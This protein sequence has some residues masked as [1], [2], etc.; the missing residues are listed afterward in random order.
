MIPY[1]T[2]PSVHLFGSVSLHAYGV[3]FVI[4]IVTAYPVIMKRAA[5]LE[6]ATRSMRRALL[7]TFAVGL[8]GAHVVEILFYQPDKLSTEGFW[9]FFRIFSGL[10]SVGA[11]F[12]GLLGLWIY[13]RRKGMPWIGHLSIVVEGFIVWWV[14]LRLGCALSHDHLGN[15]TAFVLAFNY[16]LGPRHNLGFYEFL[17]VLLV[18]I[19]LTIYCR[20]RKVQPGKYVGIMFL[21]YGALRFALDFLR[22]TDLP[23]ADPRYWGL[24]A[25]QY[26]CLALLGAGAWLL[27]SHTRIGERRLAKQRGSNLHAHDAALMT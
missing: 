21:T 9:I 15:A 25:A 8:V 16:P 20:H 1:F 12:G 26:G 11:V 17:L 4:G 23:G 14:F 10:S 13:C 22:A 27:I 7:W 2:I 24:T 5:G 3:L 6:G 19:P 18:L